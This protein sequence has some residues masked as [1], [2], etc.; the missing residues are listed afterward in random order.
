MEH[1]QG[2]QRPVR[3]RCGGRIGASDF[4]I[5]GCEGVGDGSS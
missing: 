3:T 2:R 5:G 1:G 4:V